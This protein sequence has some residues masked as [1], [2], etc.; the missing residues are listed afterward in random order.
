LP[1]RRADA[2]KGDFGRVLVLAGRRGMSGAAVLSGIAALRGGAGLVTVAC[3]L[4]IQDIVAA[5][6]PCYM[7]L[8]LPCDDD[9]AITTPAISVLK[10]QSANVLALGPGLGTSDGAAGVV[11]NLLT[12]TDTPAVVD[13]DGLN[14]LSP[15]DLKRAAP[16]ILTP[17]PGEF[18]RLSGQPAPKTH[19]E[20]LAAAVT[21]AKTH[22]LILL[23]K[24][25]R[26]IVTDGDRYFVNTTGNPGMA[27]GGSGDVLTG[28]LAALL[29]QKLDPFDA[30]C[31]GA[32]LHGAAGDHAAS[33]FGEVSMTAWDLLNALPRAIHN[34]CESLASFRSPCHPGSE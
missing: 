14:V 33:E 2:H 16:L 9:G 1:P 30:A 11:R 3:P 24:G 34:H 26:T 23:L 25:H 17:H 28:L 4:A 32:H 13:A 15:F 22:N 7:T 21:F 10:K 20:R 12:T 19:E 5:A 6:F 31:L 27:T 8:G 18:A 29:G